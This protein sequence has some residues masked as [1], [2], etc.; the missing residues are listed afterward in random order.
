LRLDAHVCFSRDHPPEHLQA[1]LA[2]NRFD[3]AILVVDGP[4][5][6]ATGPHIAGLVA[7][8]GDAG[9]HALDA[10]QH[11]GRVRGICANLER[12]VPAAAEELAKRAI[13]LDIEMRPG[14]FPALLRLAGRLP[15]LRLAIDH[16]A[17]PDFQLA[18]TE[19]WLRGMESAARLQRVFCK[20]SG[21]LTEV[22][23]LPWRAE[24]LRPF[25][26]HA[27]AVFGPDRLMF[28]SEWPARLPDITWKESLA[29][30][31]QAIGARSLETR[32]QLLGGTA[33]AFYGV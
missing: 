28:G 26:E 19:E 14:D 17:R 7:R 18:P 3:G 8:H 30:F 21:L 20:I 15:D 22:N 6:P 23:R 33:R 4:L 32:E 31:T 11:D 13:P 10:Y 24:P 2:R 1:I 25:V 5:L 16:L 29:A 27:L 12:G 9:G